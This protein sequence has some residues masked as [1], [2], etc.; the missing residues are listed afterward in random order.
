MTVRRESLSDNPSVTTQKP[1][2]IAVADTPDM[3]F[4]I[5]EAP[6]PSPRDGEVLVRIHAS[7]LNPLDAKI[8][9]SKAPHARHPLPAVLGLDLA[10]TVTGVGAGSPISKK[11]TT[12]MA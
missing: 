12:S 6:I 9:V 2:R 8:R 10:G 1:V 11:A 3:P 7:G 5:A 4:R